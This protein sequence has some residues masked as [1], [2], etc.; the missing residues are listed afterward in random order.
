MN[1]APINVQLEIADLGARSQ[2][3]KILRSM[4]GFQIL[5]PEESR[6]FDLL[7]VELGPESDQDIEQI[8]ELLDSGEAQEVFVTS[9]DATPELLRRLMRM[10]IKEFFPQ[11]LKEEEVKMAL[12]EF[13]DRRA[14]RHEPEPTKSGKII[15]VIGSKGGVGTT[16]I[17]VNLAAGLADMK[18]GYSVALV[19]MN[20]LF[21]DIPLFLNLKPNY[22]WGEITK[23]IERLDATF[24]TKIMASHSSGIQ[25][26]SS[27][28][29]L[30]GQQPATPEIIGRL[31]T[32]MQKMFDFV[33]VDGGQTL[34][35]PT[36]KIME[37]ADRVLLISLLSLPYLANTN[38]LLKSFVNQGYH[39]RDGVNIIINRYI[40]RSE[41]TLDDA[42]TSLKKEIF[43]TVPN[44]YKT[45]VSAINQGKTLFERAP[46]AEVVLNLKKLAGV[47]ATGEVKTEKK[48]GWK[49][50]GR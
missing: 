15:D 35:A 28:S 30:N 14:E 17:A 43:W 36:L 6:P 5:K 20:L 18:P 2:F 45:T 44:D 24:L 47:L 13:K 33:I 29:Y 41:V 21:G 31:L 40:K 8:A 25:I 22:H 46:R 19:D 32:L 26:L 12:R 16:T 27:P 39:P 42:K 37:M 4:E 34:N 1:E 9:P 50:F 48:G 10:G 3:E 38:K 7:I 23:N 49:L 11:P